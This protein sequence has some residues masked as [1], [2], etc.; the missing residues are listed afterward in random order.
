M[1][2]LPEAAEAVSV[3]SIAALRAADTWGLSAII[4]PS[5]GNQKAAP[6]GRLGGMNDELLMSNEPLAQRF[7]LALT[8]DTASLVEQARNQCKPL[9]VCQVGKGHADAGRQQRDQ[10]VP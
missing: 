9:C 5:F 1:R 8:V 6:F 10:L 2:S 7:D 4:L 3:S